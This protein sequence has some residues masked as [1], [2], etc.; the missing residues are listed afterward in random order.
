MK[1]V[2]LAWTVYFDT[3]D[4]PYI[5]R[6]SRLGRVVRE[7]SDGSVD[8]FIDREYKRRRVFN[9]YPG[10]K[11]YEYKV[12]RTL[13]SS[14]VLDDPLLHIDDIGVSTS[15]RWKWHSYWRKASEAA[16]LI[17]MAKRHGELDLIHKDIVRLIGEYIYATRWDSVWE[18]RTQ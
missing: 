4:P 9:L 11:V 1:R 18:S 14:I 5:A 16:C 3:E 7:Q 12:A 2:D 10:G 15:Y 13:N 8:F 6:D 17:V